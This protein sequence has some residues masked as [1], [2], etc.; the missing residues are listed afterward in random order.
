[1]SLINDALKRASSQ[2][3]SAPPPSGGPPLQPFES[4]SERNPLPI[5]LCIVGV[6]ALLMSA[7]FWLKSRGTP[8]GTQQVAQQKAVERPFVVPTPLIDSK[9][10]LQNP[11]EHAAA[12]LQKTVERN[13]EPVAAP[14]TN[15]TTVA[16]TSTPVAA[17]PAPQP[18]KTEPTPPPTPT[19][20][21]Q[22]IYFRMKGP[23]VVINGRTL[24]IGEEVDGA[25][26]VRI[27]RTSAEIEY[28][29]AREKLTMH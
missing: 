28:R 19:F 23:T 5:I 26:L 12:T 18:V 27:E 14:A 17:T 9:P 4:S 6:G 22:A 20:R 3:P 16:A 21:L 7:A 10:I 13:G 29:G 15:N 2:K 1:M 24:S 25:R 8:S 11:V